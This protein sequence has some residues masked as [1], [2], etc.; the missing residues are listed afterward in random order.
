MLSDVYVPFSVLSDFGK[1]NI[2]HG[3]WSDL[4]IVVDFWAALEGNVSL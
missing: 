1:E 4:H 3:V 2:C